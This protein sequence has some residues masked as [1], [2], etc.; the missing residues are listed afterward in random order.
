MRAMVALV[1]EQM[2]PVVHGIDVN[3][4]KTL[5]YAQFSTRRPATLRNSRSLFETR[6]SFRP[7]ACAAI[8]VSKGP[9]GVPARSSLARTLAYDTA[10]LE[11]NSTTV[12][13]RRKFSTRRIVFT[14]EE[15]FA[16]P[17]RSSPSL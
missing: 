7:S 6:I 8:N 11:V 4:S 14:G 3:L 13:G 15:L 1:E 5:L 17:V 16:A 9:I 12:S 2:Q 10:S